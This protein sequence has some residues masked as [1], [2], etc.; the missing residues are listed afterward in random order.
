LNQRAGTIR[1]LVSN[2]YSKAPSYVQ[3]IKAIADHDVA[4]LNVIAGKAENPGY[5]GRK[6][7]L[8]MS[9]DQQI[10]NA[11]SLFLRAGWN[12][13]QF[14]TWAFTEIDRTG[15]MGATVKGDQWKRPR[16]IFGVAGVL[17]GISKIHRDFLADGGYG[18]IIGDGALKYGHEGIL[19]AYYSACLASG[20]FLTGDYQFVNNPAYNKDR[21]PVSVFSL[22]VHLEF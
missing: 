4:L 3:G 22:R 17:N 8:G 7:G 14:A 19:E 12:D 16:D 13:G 18:F 20:L 5:G 11:I 9:A 2:T 10:S 21:G 6:F 1:L 15:S